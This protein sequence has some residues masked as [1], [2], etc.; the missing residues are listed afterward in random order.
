MPEL[1]PGP[2]AVEMPKQSDFGSVNW[3]FVLADSN[4]DAIDQFPITSQ[5]LISIKL[6][7]LEV[8]IIHVEA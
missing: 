7:I 1:E 3:T 8:Q 4:L 2:V 5:T 6:E